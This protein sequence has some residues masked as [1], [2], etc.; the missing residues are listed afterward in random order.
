MINLTHLLD[1]LRRWFRVLAAHHARHTK[2]LHELMKVH[3]IS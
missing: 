1:E 3:K 2:Q